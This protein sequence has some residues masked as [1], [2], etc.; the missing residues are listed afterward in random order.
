[1]HVNLWGI[2]EAMVVYFFDPVAALWMIAKFTALG[3]VLALVVVFVCVKFKAFKRQNTYWNIAAKLYFLY[4]PIVFMGAGAAYGTLEYTQT[5]GDKAIVN[6]IYPFKQ[7]MIH[8][9]QGLPPETRARASLDARIRAEIRDNLE[10]Q[11][12]GTAMAD[13]INKLPASIREWVSERLVDYALDR[14]NKK[15]ADFVGMDKKEV[16]QQWHRDMVDLLQGDFLDNLLKQ[17]FLKLMQGYQK[18]VLFLLVFL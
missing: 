18:S 7:Q 1:M 12:K 17:P 16:A 13:A 11:L 5:V 2:F 9:L 10:Q 6:F 8:Y 3:F 4:I 15:L 14:F